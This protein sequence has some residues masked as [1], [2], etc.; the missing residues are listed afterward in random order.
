ML[1]LARIGTLNR[2]KRFVWRGAADHQWR[3]APSLV[4]DFVTETGALPRELD[5]RRRELASVDEARAW[6]LAREIG[7]LATDL[8]ML[9]LLQHHGV[10][11]RLLDVTPNPM[12]ALWFACQNA[13]PGQQAGVLFAF[14]VTD[15]PTYSTINDHP[16]NGSIADPHGWT[17][18]A[19]L[20]KSAASARP[21]LVSPALPDSRMRAQEGLFIASAVPYKPGLPGVDGLTLASSTTVGVERLHTLFTEPSRTQGRPLSVPFCAIIIPRPVKE[22]MR[23]HLAAT[24]NRTE[25]SLF[26]DIAGF[27]EAWNSKR[28][29]V[30]ERED[31]IEAQLDVD[32]RT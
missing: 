30:T 1:A 19:A 6:G 10:H 28:I 21:F 26:P 22:K 29:D 3:L 18:R 16:T 8:H 24:Y 4:R 11:T 2:T 12:T 7:D 25:R 23:D 9:A 32:A 14:D 20:S 27:R 31:V 17:L 13:P 15:A 5:I